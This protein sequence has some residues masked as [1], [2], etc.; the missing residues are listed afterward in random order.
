MGWTS[1][2]WPSPVLDVTGET[3]PHY[4]SLTDAALEGYDTNAKMNPPLR[5]EEDGWRSSRGSR[6]GRSMRSPATR[7]TSRTSR[8]ASSPSLP[9]AIAADLFR[10]RLPCLR[11]ERSCRRVSSICSPR[12]RADLASRQGTLAAGADADVTVID[13]DANGIRTR[14]GALEVE[15]QPLPRVE[16]AWPA[17]ATICGGGS[18]IRRSREWRW[19]PDGSPS[20]L[21]TARFS[22][23]A[24]RLRGECSRR[25]RLQHRDDRVP[26]SAH[27]SSITGRSS[28]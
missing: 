13:R 24:L 4:F 5:G 25:G 15:E 23:G 26:G 18:V 6:T 21:A 19:M 2:G 20:R 11:G 12:A 27:G 14:R 17:A 10:S 16:D 28:Q 22:K 9:P 7:P 8:S 1:S 3:A